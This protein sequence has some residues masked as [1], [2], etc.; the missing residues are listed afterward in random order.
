MSTSAPPLVRK[1]IAHYVS[2]LP[3]MLVIMI[4]CTGG[5]PFQ[6]IHAIKPGGRERLQKHELL[7]PE[8]WT[9]VE[10]LMPVVAKTRTSVILDP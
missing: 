9:T 8:L 1:R 2:V 4:Q 6:H 5:S 7:F 10:S 3:A